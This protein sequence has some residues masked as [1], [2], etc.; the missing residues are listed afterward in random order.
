MLIPDPHTMPLDAIRDWHAEHD[1]CVPFTLQS[2]A[3]L[4][5]ERGRGGVLRLRGNQGA[6]P[7]PPTLDGA[8]SSLPEGYRWSRRSNH[9]GVPSWQAWH[10]HDDA[11]VPVLS[12]PDTGDKIRDLFTLGMLAKLA[13]QENKR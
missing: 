2:G 4:W 10:V 6:H 3:V 7:Y 1:G 9:K 5:Q 12:T 11:D 8:D 13:E